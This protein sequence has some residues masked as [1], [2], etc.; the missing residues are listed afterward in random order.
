M[1]E[2][3]L[4]LVLFIHIT[5]HSTDFFSFSSCSSFVNFYL[6][7]SSKLQ[8]YPRLLIL[9]TLNIFERG[10]FYSLFRTM[11]VSVSRIRIHRT[12]SLKRTVFS[13]LSRF[14][15]SFKNTKF[16]FLLVMPFD[17]KLRS[18]WTYLYTYQYT[19]LHPSS[20][21]VSLV[22]SEEITGVNCF[23]VVH[24]TNS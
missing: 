19:S 7:Y 6:F 5:L 14:Q 1:I 8:T 22:L 4:G 12:I 2:F 13:S 24:L 9:F 15:Q 18:M 20:C 10:Y 3:F 17:S 21:N 23:I 11:V 16:W